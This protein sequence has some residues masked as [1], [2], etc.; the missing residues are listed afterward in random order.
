MCRRNFGNI[1]R[2]SAG[3]KFFVY[4][5]LQWHSIFCTLNTGQY[6]FNV[7]IFILIASQKLVRRPARLQNVHEYTHIT[8]IHMLVSTKLTITLAH[9]SITNVNNFAFYSF[10]W[11]PFLCKQV[12]K[13]TVKY[14]IEMLRDMPNTMWIEF[15][16]Q[17]E[18]I[19]FTHT[20]PPTRT[21]T[22]TR[23]HAYKRHQ[24]TNK[25]LPKKEKIA[26]QDEV[27][28]K[29]VTVNR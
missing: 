23:I 2:F 18:R 10:V 26:C 20:R 24:C 11:T 15:A 16:I 29:V 7:G 28:A 8:T 27:Y 12:E 1:L 17:R 19:C 25:T 9:T 6:V 13:G 14:E 3:L 4:C 21:H 5:F 22:H